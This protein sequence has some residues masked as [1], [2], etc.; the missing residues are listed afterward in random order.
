MLV[1]DIWPGATSSNPSSLVNLN[2]MLFFAARTARTARELWKSDGT[3]AGT[4]LVRDIR[5]GTSSSSPQSLTA[6]G[7]TLFFGANDAAHGIELWALSLDRDDDGS[8]IATSSRSGPTRWTP[9]ATTTD[10]DDGEEV[11]ALGTD[12]S[13]PTA[14]TT[15]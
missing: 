10:S 3:A 14:T 5:S 4:E 1:H 15:G 8:P 11:L 6:V 12:P 2:G 9:T 7:E 13:T